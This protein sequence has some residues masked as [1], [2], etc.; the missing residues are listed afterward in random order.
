MPIHI[1]HVYLAFIPSQ[2]VF[3][4]GVIQEVDNHQVALNTMGDNCFFC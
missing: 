3:L 1:V 2:W 4:Q